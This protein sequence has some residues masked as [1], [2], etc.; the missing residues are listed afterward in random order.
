MFGLPYT[1]ISA[2][3]TFRGGDVL[4]YGKLSFKVILTPGHTIGSCC[5]LCDNVCFSGD[6]LF[7]ESVGRTDF[8][9]GSHAEL[10]SSIKK[11]LLSLPD[12]TTVCPGHNEQTTIAHERLFN[13]YLV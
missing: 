1:P 12:E 10:I 6:T 7:C 4:T 8:P 5:F 13:P 2:D 9:T 3:F 11:K